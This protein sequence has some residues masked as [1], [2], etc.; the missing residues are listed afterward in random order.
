MNESVIKFLLTAVTALIVLYI[1]NHISFLKQ[2]F[3]P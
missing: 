1:V 2:I 3:N